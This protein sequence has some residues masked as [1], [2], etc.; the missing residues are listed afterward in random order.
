MI[1]FQAESQGAE[2]LGVQFMQRQWIPAFAGMTMMGN[3]P[4]EIVIP[5]KAGIHRQVRETA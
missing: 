2:V 4:A 5:A 3:G 1:H